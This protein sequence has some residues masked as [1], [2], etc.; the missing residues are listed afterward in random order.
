MILPFLSQYRTKL[1]I[2]F[3][4]TPWQWMMKHFCVFR[5][6]GLN[7]VKELFKSVSVW[8]ESQAYQLQET[9]DQLSSLCCE[10][11]CFLSRS[12]SFHILLMRGSQAPANPAQ[13]G[14]TS[15]WRENQRW[16][17]SVHS[18]KTHPLMLFDTIFLHVLSLDSGKI[19]H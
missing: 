12:F 11:S 4:A 14:M 18:F 1:Y 19:H 10:L 6:V 2:V 5:C 3:S 16:F 13:D 17:D 8:S 7:K 9:L 15:S